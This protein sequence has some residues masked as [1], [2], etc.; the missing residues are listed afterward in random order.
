MFWEASDNFSYIFNLKGMSHSPLWCLPKCRE[1]I[2]KLSEGFGLGSFPLAWCEE[3]HHSTWGGSSWSP[4]SW[5][6]ILFQFPTLYAFISSSF[7]H[8]RFG[9]G[10]GVSDR[11]PEPV[12]LRYFWRLWEWGVQDSWSISS[13]EGR[14][15][16]RQHRILMLQRAG[17]VRCAE[18]HGCWQPGLQI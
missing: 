11:T 3:W 13:K 5:K 17:Q 6:K 10:H 7:F 15:E 12:S 4:H 2:M 9:R 14:S 8:L 1:N 18:G 16:T